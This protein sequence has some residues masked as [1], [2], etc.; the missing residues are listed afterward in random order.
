MSPTTNL[1]LKHFR[2]PGKFPTFNH[3]MRTSLF[4]ILYLFLGIYSAAQELVGPD[5]ISPGTLA[6]FEIIPAQEAAWHIVPP[7]LNPGRYQV[8]SSLSKLYFASSERG[9]FTIVAG[10]IVNGKSVLLVK[11]FIN[12]DKDEKPQPPVSSLEAWV[13]QQLPVLVKS[14]NLASE[15]QLVAGRF[16]EIVRRIDEDNIK[17]ASNAHAQLHMALTAS[18][19]QASSTAITD[20]TPFLMELSRR[21]EMELGDNMNDLIAIQKALRNVGSAMQS[22]ELS[23]TVRMP[24]S[25][26]DSQSNREQ[27]T[28]NRTFR[29]LLTR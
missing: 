28:Q 16:E 27:G 14:D 8:D 19:A 18:L 23:N 22:L 9:R 12:D 7:S 11:T 1:I 24:L 20:W 2:Y 17:T 6:S 21:L 13:K 25:N 26:L 29:T 3:T 5:C 4:F 10:I 15:V